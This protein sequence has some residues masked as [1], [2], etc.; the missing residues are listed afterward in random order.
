MYVERKSN[1]FNW[2]IDFVRFVEHGVCRD[3]CCR[4]IQLFMK[5]A[6]AFQ[7]TGNVAFY[8]QL[9]ANDEHMPRLFPHISHLCFAFQHFCFLS[10]TLI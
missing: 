4:V 9:L 2:K 6:C 8:R 1:L 3:F 7:R 5:I 10:V